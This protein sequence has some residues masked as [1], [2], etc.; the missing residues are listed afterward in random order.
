MSQ[1]IRMPAATH[2]ASDLR[3]LADTS[4]LARLGHHADVR[5]ALEP[6]L[7]EGQLAWCDVTLLEMGLTARNSDDHQGLG[8]SLRA[9]PTVSIEPSDFARAWEVQGSLAVR[10]RHRGVAL[11]DLLVAACAERLHLTVIH[12]DA[13]FDLIA[14]VTGQEARWALDRRRL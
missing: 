10:G 9:L 6:L 2:G 14:S 12:C 5:A 8:A 13:D 11:P 7:R 1:W 4:A 3:Y